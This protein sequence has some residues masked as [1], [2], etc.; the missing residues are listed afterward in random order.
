MLQ[1][2][3]SNFSKKSHIC[4]LN[5]LHLVIETKQTKKNKASCSAGKKHT[6]VEISG[7]IPV[8]LSGETSLQVLTAS[9]MKLI[10]P[11]VFSM[12]IFHFSM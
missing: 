12:V 3:V 4:I 9:T 10:Y 6:S 7:T 5:C 2:I 1:I 11:Y 8:C